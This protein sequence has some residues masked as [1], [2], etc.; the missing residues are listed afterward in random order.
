MSTSRKDIGH[1]YE[2]MRS[3]A[4]SEATAQAAPAFTLPQNF[5]MAS[6]NKSVLDTVQTW[7]NALASWNWARQGSSTR[8]S[9]FHVALFSGWEVIGAAFGRVPKGKTHV[10][11]DLMQRNP[12]ST[13]GKGLVTPLCVLAAVNYASVIQ[14]RRVLITNPVDKEDVH[15]QYE[16]F[17]T[18]VKKGDSPFAGGHY[19]VNLE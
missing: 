11:I 2:V 7:E 8:P 14:A 10:R 12:S 5:Y 13:A 4:F 1:Y 18:Y 17:G 3:R 6:L 16:K 15:R 19:V 9:H